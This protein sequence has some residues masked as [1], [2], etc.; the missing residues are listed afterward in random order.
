MKVRYFA[1]I[2]SGFKE[3]YPNYLNAA[4]ETTCKAFSNSW[5]KNHIKVPETTSTK[6]KYLEGKVTTHN[7]KS[8]KIKQRDPKKRHKPRYGVIS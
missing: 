6:K 7:Q 3:F 2:C 1:S 5:E 4:K 8:Y